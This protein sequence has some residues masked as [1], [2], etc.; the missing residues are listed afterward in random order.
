MAS[1]PTLPPHVE[2]GLPRVDASL[3]VTGGAVYSSD[4]SL[5]GMLYAVPVCASIAKGKIISLD[6]KKA[7]TMPGVK[8]IFSRHNIGKLWKTAPGERSIAHVDEHRPPFADDIIRYFG[9][10]VAAVVAQNFEQASAAAAAVKVV[11]ETEKPDVRD[12]LE[13]DEKP[14]VTSHRGNPDQAFNSAPVKIDHVYGTPVETHNPMELHASVATFDGQ[15]FTLFETTQGVVNARNALAQ[16]LG[17]NTENVRVIS[18]FLGS[19]FGSK[20][21]PWP[22]SLIAASAARNLGHPIKLVVSRAMMFQNVGHRP[23]TEQRLRIGATSTGKLLSLMHDSINHT[24]ILDNYTEHC[25]E[26]TSFSYSTRNLRTTSGLARRNV[27]NPTAMRGPGAVPGLYALES[28][29]DELAIKLKMDPVELRLKNE[30]EIDE[31]LN[32]PFSS[33]H[34]KECLT[35]GAEKFG[36]ARRTPEV[37]SMKRDGLTIGWGVA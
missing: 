6:T 28:A 23:R 37:G 9:Q 31:S 22:H 11:Y 8:A 27:G 35:V 34:M 15:N 32:I 18:R 21:F 10:Y 33:R 26:A 7:E 4:F 14:R 3:K 16:M 5:P 20:L 29:M 19:G 12:H 1:L 25:T 30:P 17:V 36:W 13:A 2:G 24:S